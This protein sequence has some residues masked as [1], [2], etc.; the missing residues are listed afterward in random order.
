[1]NDTDA[2][3]IEPEIDPADIE[4]PAALGAEIAAVYGVDSVETATDWLD[5]L[6]SGLEP[7][8]R[9]LGIDDL[10]TTEN[11]DHVLTTPDGEQAYQCVF[12]PMIVPFVTGDPGTVRSACPTS[13]EETTIDIGVDGVYA[14]PE[15]AVFSF[16]VAANAA[17]SLGDPPLTP[18]ETYGSCCPY[19][20]AFAT[21]DAYES[22]A[23]ETDAITTAV[24]LE[25]GVALVGEMANRL[26]SED[27]GGSGERPDCACC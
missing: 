1:M 11:S 24:P 15:T 10:C 25:Y 9:T 22:W 27:A 26:V 16:G 14:S 21:R 23:A 4:L 12:D 5:A 3:R 8:G 6:E 13:G 19:G 7:T 18:R 17:A 2:T 20:N